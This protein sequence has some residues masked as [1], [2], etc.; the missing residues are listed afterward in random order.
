MRKGTVFLV[1]LLTFALVA[2]WGETK[3]SGALDI[4][5]IGVAELPKGMDPM[6]GI[7]NASMRV[8]YNIFETLIQ[9]DPKENYS[10]KP[11]LAESWERIN[12]YTMEFKLRKGVKFHNGTILT[13][14][15]VAFSFKRLKEKIPNIELA[16]SLMASIKDVQVVDDYTCRV[17]TGKVDPILED[18]I[19]S[20]WGAWILPESYLKKVGNDGFALNPVGTGPFKVVSFSRDK[21]VLERFEDYWGPKPNVK[22]IEYIVYPETSTRMIALMTGEVDLITQVPP[23]QV[24]VIEKDQKLKI[25]SMPISNMHV[26]TYNTKVPALSDK[27]L[28]Q[29]M[30]LAINRQLLVDTLWNGKAKVPRGHQYPEYDDLYFTDFP[31]EEYDLKKAKQLVAESSYKGDVLEFELKSGYYTFGNEAVL[32]IVD[33]WK[34]AGINAQIVFHDPNQYNQ[35][36]LWSN[37]MRFPDPVGGLW[38]LWGT[39]STPA[40]KTWTDMPAEFVSTGEK[41]ASTIDPKKRKELARRLMTIW[42]EEA[43]GTLLYFPY[44]SWGIRKGLDWTPYS[45]QAMDFRA[46]NFKVLK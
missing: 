45:S 20:S 46:D 8:H 24:P 6:L 40:L 41:L 26:L 14:G 25:L 3:N 19:A 16:A 21:V 30:N 17:I 13:A 15:D 42:E 22:R 27:K 2:S 35:V 9:A 29:A 28:R 32:A 39:G 34:Q 4:L 38:L 23:D 5:R 18:R 11:M 12:D 37:T 44:E 1:V 10:K 33:M 43:P 31:V 7:G 36:T